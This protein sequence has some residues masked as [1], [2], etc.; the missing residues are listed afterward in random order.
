LRPDAGDARVFSL[1]P[2]R[3]GAD[4][5]A[6]IGYVPE[7]HDV[8]YGWMRVGRMLER[9]AALYPNWD[10]AYGKR[11]AS[12][13]EL[14]LDRRFGVLSKGQARRVQ[15]VLALAHR[16]PLL[17][18]DEPTDGLDPVARDETLS[19]LAEHLATNP[20]SVLLSTHRIYE[21]ERLAD[22]V[23]I[24]REGR[25]VAQTSNERLRGHLLR[26]RAEIP[27][28][29]KAPEGM[30]GVVKRR[31][32]TG[33][34]ILWTVWGEPDDIRGRLSEAGATVRETSP[35]TLDEAAIALLASEESR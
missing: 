34:E 10:P 16:P 26:Y 18:L 12:T 20:T 7:G 29:W 2:L 27:E 21:V 25:L 19:L 33:R 23:G 14:R 17:L 6:R 11:L 28:S 3:A 13:L 32:G 24:L 30:N 8:G 35:M 4:I 15:L 31:A 9:H 5:R 1:D 22:H